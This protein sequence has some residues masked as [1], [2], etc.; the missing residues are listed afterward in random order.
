MKLSKKSTLLAAITALTINSYA[1]AGSV[2]GDAELG[3]SLSSGNSDVDTVNGKADMDYQTGR[4]IHNAFID[5]FSGESNGVKTAERY[6]LGLKP[7]YFLTTKNYV[8][9]LYRFDK[10]KFAGIDSQHTEVLGFGRKILDNPDEG[11]SVEMGA[12]ARQTDFVFGTNTSNVDE[13]EA[14]Y[15]LGAF[16]DLRMSENMRFVQDLRV[17]IGEDNNFVES[18]SGLQFNVSNDLSAKISYTM[19]HNSDI[20]GVNGTNTDTVTGVSLLYSF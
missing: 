7:R 14:I 19:R 1:I 6:T 13:N 4:W 16:Y 8:F 18:I 15:F 11:L 3:V 20:E 9:G 17:E 12:G 10:D 2:T 5:V